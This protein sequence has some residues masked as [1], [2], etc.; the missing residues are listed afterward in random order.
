[1]KFTITMKDP[2]GFFDCVAEAVAEEVNKMG[3]A[4]DDERDAVKET[5][6]EKVK[7]L[8]KTWFEYGEYLTVEVD[9]EAKTCVVTSAPL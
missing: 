8:L 9:I 7:E 1:M 4:D 2:D 3:I 5:K 6:T